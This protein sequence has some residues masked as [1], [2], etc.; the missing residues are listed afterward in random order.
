MK[1]LSAAI[2]H[3]ITE[4]QQRTS[5]LPPFES[6]EGYSDDNAKH[7]GCQLPSTA[8]ALSSSKAEKQHSQTAVANTEE[9]S[10]L[11]DLQ[12][13]SEGKHKAF[14]KD[15][16]EA[17]VGDSHTATNLQEAQIHRESEKVQPGFIAGQGDNGATHARV[18]SALSLSDFGGDPGCDTEPRTYIQTSHPNEPGL[19]PEPSGMEVK[20][21]STLS[22]SEDGNKSEASHP[23]DGLANDRDLSSTE[24]KC[25]KKVLFWDNTVDN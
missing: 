17:D 8:A 7:L 20:V 5:N 15:G 6:S 18:D 22:A 2:S 16:S 14:D 1:F 10:L 21:E 19:E 9:T 4:E 12:P 24:V 11:S 13:T 25:P 3:R 23:R